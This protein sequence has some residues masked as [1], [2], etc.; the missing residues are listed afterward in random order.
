MIPFAG[1]SCKGEMRGRDPLGGCQGLGVQGGLDSQS[2]QKLGE[3]VLFCVL[4]MVVVMGRYVFDK[5][6]FARTHRS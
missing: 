3:A 4:L 5:H 2:L 6:V 1:Y